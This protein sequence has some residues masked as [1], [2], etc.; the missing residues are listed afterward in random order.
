MATEG[1]VSII[2][3]L[4]GSFFCGLLPLGIAAILFFSSRKRG[5]VGSAIGTARKTTIAA[6]QPTAES[7][8]LQGAINPAGNAFDGPPESGTVYLRLKGE[9]Y[10]SD[11]DS[12]GWRGFTDQTR[13]VPFK[14]EDGTGSVWVD[15]QGLDKQLTGEAA[16]PSEDQVQAASILLGITPRRMSG[17]VRYFLWEMRGSQT[18][19]VLGNVFQDPAGLVLKHSPGKPFV[20]SP[21]LGDTLSTAV[22]KQK[23]TIRIW[24]YVLGIPGAV[25]LLCGLAGALYSL[26]RVLKLF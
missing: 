1:F 3:W 10:E 2:A 9:V 15:P 18:V 26:A 21:L 14:L 23:N 22:T 6:L 13:A 8:R 19:T 4:A 24:M 17:H 12:S 11:E 7:V 5:Q 16:T 25:F 20:V